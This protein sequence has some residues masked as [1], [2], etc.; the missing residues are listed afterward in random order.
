MAELNS[1]SGIL[2]MLSIIVDFISGFGFGNGKQFVSEVRIK[3]TS[4]IPKDIIA[5][6][7]FGN[8]GRNIL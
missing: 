7:D 5:L 8:L 2:P 1:Y 4:M 6:S 3:V